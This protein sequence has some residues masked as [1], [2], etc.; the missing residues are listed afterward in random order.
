MKRNR[1]SLVRLIAFALLLNAAFLGM[2]CSSSSDLSV[3]EA[4]SPELLA[5]VDSLEDDQGAVRGALIEAL[6]R[7]EDLEGDSGA[8]PAGAVSPFAGPA[9]NLP[10][11]WLNCD[12]SE[13]SR[14]E[15]EDLFAA[16]GTAHGEG[17]GAT[18]FNLPDYRGMFLRGV[19]NGAGNDPDGEDRTDQGKSTYDGD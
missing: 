7:I 14:D 3:A 13:V 15:Y 6:A 10:G 1:D 12:G 11:G 4:D 18:T 2:R 5:R 9:A 16:I 19:D 8:T 17:D